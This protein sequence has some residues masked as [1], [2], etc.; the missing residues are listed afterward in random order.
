MPSYVTFSNNCRQLSKT[1]IV[2]AYVMMLMKF[3]KPLWQLLQSIPVIH[4]KNINELSQGYATCGP[5]A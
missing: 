3:F 2:V 4:R 1:T 5:R